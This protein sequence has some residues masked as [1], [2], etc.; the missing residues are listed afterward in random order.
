MTIQTKPQPQSPTGA[1]LLRIHDVSAVTGLA[2]TTIRRM[3]REGV[4]PAP[5]R[6]SQSARAWVPAE[7]DAW[8]DARI[9]ER[10]ERRA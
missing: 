5:V 2:P 1:R 9:A 6:I 8:V 10:D 7:V 3:S 4:F